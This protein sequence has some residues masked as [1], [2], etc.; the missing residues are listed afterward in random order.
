MYDTTAMPDGPLVNESSTDFAEDLVEVHLFAAARAAYGANSVSVQPGSLAKVL[1]GLVTTA[2]DLASVL[3][4]C[5]FLI[6]GYVVTDASQHDD[7]NLSAGDRLDVLPP[8][9]G[10]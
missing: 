5:S 4:R 1:L 7:Q 6:N 9:A 8:F 10:G 2:P 3:P